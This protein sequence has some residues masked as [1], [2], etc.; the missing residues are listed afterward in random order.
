MVGDGVN[1]AT[2]LAR[3]NVGIAM[4]SIGSDVSLENA[5]IALMPDDPSKQVYLVGMS[6]KTLEIVRENMI[7]SIL[8]KGSFAVL[9]FPRLI[10]LWLAV[11]SGDMGLSL[12][13]ILNSLQL[14]LLKPKKPPSEKRATGETKRVRGTS[15]AFGGCVIAGILS[16]SKKQPR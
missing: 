1:D 9:A 11:A 3:A 5:D 14:T 12:A 7:S 13:V 6:K 10:T 8:V 15:R 2:A 4:G 16:K